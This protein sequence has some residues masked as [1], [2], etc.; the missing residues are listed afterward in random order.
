MTVSATSDVDVLQQVLQHRGGQHQQQQQ[1]QPGAWLQQ[2]EQQ[3]HYQ[4]QQWGRQQQGWEQGGQQHEQPATLLAPGYAFGP[5]AALAATTLGPPPSPPIPHSMT[6]TP[7]PAPASPSPPLSPAPPPPHFARPPPLL[8]TLT[9]LP[10]RATPA[11]AARSPLHT[12]GGA[13]SNRAQLRAHFT[14][15]GGAR[16][17]TAP[18]V[19]VR[20]A[21]VRVG[22]GGCFS[23]RLWV[24]L[25]VAQGSWPCVWCGACAR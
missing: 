7:E 8:T 9:L 23:A 24:G 25:R 16:W 15:D 19:A 11:H 18:F 4:H 22:Q 6:P 1:Q 13:P 14:L 20:T 5:S 12:L 10:R 21:Q 17:R 2:Q 3:Q